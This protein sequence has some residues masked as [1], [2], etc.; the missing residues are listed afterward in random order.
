MSKSGI[1]ER[2]KVEGLG[3]RRARRS[4]AP[5]I[6]R[7]GQVWR[8]RRVRVSVRVRKKEHWSSVATHIL[9]HIL[10]HANL[11]GVAGGARVSWRPIT[12]QIDNYF[13]RTIYSSFGPHKRLFYMHARA[14]ERLRCVS[15]AL[16]IATFR[17]Y[18]GLLGTL[19]PFQN[20]Y[21]ASTRG[22][23]GFVGSGWVSST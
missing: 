15:S 11:L 5:P 6:V 18:N 9:I 13:E 1:L 8:E 20:W 19:A 21:R 10:V 22:T 7:R 2:A 16:R 17:T 4:A 12:E 3:S 14:R 23:T